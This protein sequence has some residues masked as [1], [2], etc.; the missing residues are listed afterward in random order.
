[1]RKRGEGGVTNILRT[2]EALHRRLLRTPQ[3]L[4]S[5]LLP[6]CAWLAF[7]NC[8]RVSSI[9]VSL[10]EEMTRTS[11]SSANRKLFSPQDG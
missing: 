4:N 11:P 10:W 1:M 8:T 5:S 2:N 6:A 7:R 9:H 3:P